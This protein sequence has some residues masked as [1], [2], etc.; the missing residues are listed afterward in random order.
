MTVRISASQYSLSPAVPFAFGS[1][2]PWGKPASQLASE[3]GQATLRHS[4]SYLPFLFGIFNPIPL[5]TRNRDSPI[6]E[7]RRKVGLHAW[8]LGV[9]PQVGRVA[10]LQAKRLARWVWVAVALGWGNWERDVMMERDRGVSSVRYGNL[11]GDWPFQWRW[12]A[13]VRQGRRAAVFFLLVR[14]ACVKVAGFRIESIVESMC[15][16]TRPACSKRIPHGP[17][18]LRSVE[19]SVP[20]CP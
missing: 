11:T 13:A 14:L 2:S 4:R 15:Y 5:R 17:R 19:A 9:T 10:F 20:P 16:S 7:M 3:R 8:C 1:R 6:S 18:L 12:C